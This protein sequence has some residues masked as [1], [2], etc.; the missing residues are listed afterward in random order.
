MHMFT[1]KSISEINLE[2]G[3]CN[4]SYFGVIFRRL[5]GMTPYDYRR[6]RVGSQVSSAT[7]R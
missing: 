3:F 7:P 2:T 6:N 4:E 5:T 1:G